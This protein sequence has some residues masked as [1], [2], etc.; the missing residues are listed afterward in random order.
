M[1]EGVST[2]ERVARALLIFAA[3]VFTFIN[4]ILIFDLNSSQFFVPPTAESALVSLSFIGL[5]IGVL[6]VFI[7]KWGLTRE[8]AFELY[9]LD[10]VL[11]LCDSG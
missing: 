4:A 3:T 1:T 10:G 8:L 7:K 5:S 9:S 11:D 6:S 2:R